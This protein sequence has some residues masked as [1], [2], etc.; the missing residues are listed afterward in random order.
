MAFEISNFIIDRVIRGVMTSTSDGSVMYAINQIED[1]SLSISA[2]EKTAVDALGTTIATF[3]LAKNAEFSA[4]NSLFDLSLLATQMGTEKKIASTDSRIETPIFETIDVTGTTAT[5]KFTPKTGAIDAIY[6]LNG[7]STL[8][9]KYLPDTSAAAKKFAYN[10]SSKTITLPTDVKAG[11]QIFVM[12]TADVE[13]AVGVTA[14][15]TEFPKAG[16]FVMEVLGCD[17]CN[18]TE[19]I[20]AYVIFPNAKL[21][22]NVEISFTTDSKHPFTMKAQQNY[23]SKEKELFSIVIPQLG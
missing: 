23:C 14:S 16:R 20:Y 19:L 8:G 6:V 3:N 11:D 21:D 9:V 22:S 1:P 12:Y 10:N 5:L 18:P 13:N 2:D 17:V 4:S 7:D 15:A